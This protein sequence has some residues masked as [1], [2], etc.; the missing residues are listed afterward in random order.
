MAAQIAGCLVA[1]G[2]HC[3]LKN[4]EGWTP[5]HTAI[6]KNQISAIKWCVHYNKKIFEILQDE[7]LDYGSIKF[8]ND[9]YFDFERSGG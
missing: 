2:A 3:N 8:Y 1:N 6:R 7:L 4:K 9:T 5:V